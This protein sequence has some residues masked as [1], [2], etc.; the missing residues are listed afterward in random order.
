MPQ[1]GPPI[2]L[3]TR[4]LSE[5]PSEFLAPVLVNDA[6]AVRLAAVVS[7]LL[8]DL[9]GE[10]LT[11]AGAKHFESKDSRRDDE[12]RLVLIASW[13]LHDRWFIDRHSFGPAAR[14]FLAEGLIALAKI[15]KPA[16]F[17]SD[18]DR[19]EELARLCLSALG[20][21]PAGESET[22]ARDRLTTLSSVERQRVLAETRRAQEEQR[23]RKIE[24]EMARRKA[25]EA[26]PAWGRE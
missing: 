26:A 17:V 19:R 21:V 12:L 20:L 7:D 2:E 16:K 11:P 14:T 24:E 23:R 4:R 25:A 5:T 10:P 18:P 8:S 1:P 6:K 22:V 3:L 13:L 9:G 15:V